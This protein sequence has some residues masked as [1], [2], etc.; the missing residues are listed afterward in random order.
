M[1]KLFDI[2]DLIFGI[3]SWFIQFIQNA[4]QIIT[5]AFTLLLSVTAGAPA[6]LL[7]FFGIFSVLAIV[8]FVWRLIP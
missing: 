4:W 8:M 5:T 6:V 1:G 2:L 3:F 7:A